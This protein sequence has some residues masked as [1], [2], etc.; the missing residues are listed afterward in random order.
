MRYLLLF[1]TLSLLSCGSGNGTRATIQTNRGDI[2]VLLYKDTPRH[3]DNFIRLAEEGFYNGTLF[4]RVVPGFMVQGGDP[5][6]KGAPAGMPLGRGGPGYELEPEIG[7]PHLKGALAAA[8]TPNP[9][10]LS[11]GSQFYIVT[12]ELFTDQQLDNVER[13][14]NIKYSDAQREAYRTVGG[15]PDLDQ[16]YT[17]FGE[18][19]AGMDIVEGIAEVDTDPANRPLEDVVIENVIIR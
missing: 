7:A 18:V 15:R 6:S 1:L 8:R 3:T 16:D 9:Q 17:V 13:I 2:E 10:K 14:K 4:H 5:D 11:S 19:T 12:G